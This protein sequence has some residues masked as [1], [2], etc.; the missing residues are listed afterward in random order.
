M[1]KDNARVAVVTDSTCDLGPGGELAYGMDIVPLTVS[2]GEELFRDGYDLSSAEFYQR[3][4]KAS[5]L[6]TTSQPSPAVFGSVF[7]RRLDEGKEVVGIF[8]SATL[9]GTYQ[10]AAHAKSLF[11]ASEQER[12][13]LI[14]SKQGT[15]GLAILALEACALRDQGASAADIERHLSGVIPRVRLY[16]ILDTLKYLR[17]GGRLSAAAAITGGIINIVPI[18]SLDDGVIVTAAKIRRGRNSFCKWLRERLNAK[19]PDPAFPAT[20]L[21]SNDPASIALLQDEFKYLLP[22]ERALRL[23]LGAVIGTHAG[24]GALGMVYVTKD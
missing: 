17:M 15:G 10:S 23:S 5:V 4:S 18:I 20:Y 6:P 24:P 22:P 13:C 8:I 16:A 11:S 19:L 7:K 3:L 14:D 9:S 12:I 1:T 2:F 21:H